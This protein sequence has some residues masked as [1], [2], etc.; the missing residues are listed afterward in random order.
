MAYFLS[1]VL[2]TFFTL[3][4]CGC[5]DLEPSA[6][7]GADDEVLARGSGGV[8]T[9]DAAVAYLE[10]LEFTLSELGQ[11]TSFDADQRAQ[12]SQQLAATFAHLPG[13][14]QTALATARTSWTQHHLLWPTLSL[15]AKQRFAYD[16]LALAFGEATAAR[17]LGL[18]GGAERSRRAGRDRNII[19]MLPPTPWVID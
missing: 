9:R 8:F 7:P 6:S 3:Y 19:D 4:S 5:T 12:L 18:G 14:W 10:A 15:E 13:N 2:L 1:I 11:P 17:A 16:V